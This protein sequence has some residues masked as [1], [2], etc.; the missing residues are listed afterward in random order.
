MNQDRKEATLKFSFLGFMHRKLLWRKTNAKLQMLLGQKWPKSYLASDVS[1]QA[2]AFG[3][4]HLLLQYTPQSD[5]KYKSLQQPQYSHQSI[6][7]HD[8]NE[9]TR[10]LDPLVTVLLMYWYDTNMR[11]R[12]TQYI[13]EGTWSPYGYDVN[14]YVNRLFQE[15]IHSSQRLLQSINNLINGMYFMQDTFQSSSVILEII[16]R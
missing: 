9:N 2:D 14:D 12:T 8:T 5:L 10:E 6:S 7:R 15:S 1:C 3:I 4:N 16:E 13:D 11:A